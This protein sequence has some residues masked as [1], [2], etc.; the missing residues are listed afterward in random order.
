[1][2]QAMV[3]DARDINELAFA[4]GALSHYLADQYGHSKATNVTV[5]LLKQN[6]KLRKKY[7]DFITYS[8]DHTSHSRLEFSFDVLQ[9]TRGDYTSQAYHD[10]IGFKVAKPVLERAF[11]KTY[12]RKLDDMF[13]DFNSAVNTLRWG[14][15]NL[16]PAVVKMTWKTQ[17]DSIIKRQPT[18]T[19]KKF[20]YRL[21]KREFYAEFGK[22]YE[23]EG[24]TAGLI[25]FIIRLAPKIGPFKTFK[26]VDPGKAGEK[27]FVKSFDT[28]ESCFATDLVKIQHRTLMLYNVDFDTGRQTAIDEYNMADQSY[29]K[30]MIKL[31]QTGFKYITPAIKNHFLMFYHDPQLILNS[32]KYPFNC[33]KLE[34][35]IGNLKQI[36]TRPDIIMSNSGKIIFRPGIPWR[37][38]EKGGRYRAIC[39]S[40]LLSAVHTTQ[41]RVW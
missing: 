5:P 37:S 18:I 23:H 40:S 6:K 36:K 17:R 32:P 35:A 24:V 9:V 26:F 7:G 19:E 16:I 11:L 20:R 3:D 28:I 33:D 13:R 10:F 29:A 22:A 41:T 38:H 8:D 12:G 39:Q 15:N 30:W 4:I 21:K 14:V 2:I 25:A 34:Q 27:L 31:N 1:M